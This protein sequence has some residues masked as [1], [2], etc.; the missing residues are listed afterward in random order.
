MK[1]QCWGLKTR[2]GLVKDYGNPNA[3]FQT[4]TFKSRKA[5]CA[6]LAIH[7]FYKAEPVK[8]SVSVSIKEF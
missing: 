1:I 4:R 6:F 3:G 5:A 2:Q 8:I 7:P